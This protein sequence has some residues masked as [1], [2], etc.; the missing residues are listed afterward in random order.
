MENTRRNRE[1][2]EQ[3]VRQRLLQYIGLGRI[4]VLLV[5]VFSL[6]NQLLFWCKVNYHFLL[7]ASAPH[8]LNWL[9][10]VLAGTSVAGFLKFV[11]FLATPIAFVAYGASWYLSARRRH[12]IKTALLLYSADTLFLVVFALGC[13]K[14]PLN[15]LLEFLVHVIGLAVLYQAHRSAQQLHRM[16]RKRRPRPNSQQTESGE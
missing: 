9:S 1:P 8:Y 15:C 2:R 3:K 7:S 14:N 13:I 6:I 12:I 4:V 11:A 16:S 5:L 10:R